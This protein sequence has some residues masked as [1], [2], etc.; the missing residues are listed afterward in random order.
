M[1]SRFLHFLQISFGRFC[2]PPNDCYVGIKWSKDTLFLVD[3]EPVG[4]KAL[5]SSLRIILTY[6]ICITNGI[7][8]FQKFQFASS[9]FHV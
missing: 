7:F 4:H 5:I 8:S 1:V 6:A 2:H 9:V 3:F